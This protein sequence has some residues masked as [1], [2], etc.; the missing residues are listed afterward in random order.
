MPETKVLST[1]KDP[2]AVSLQRR[3]GN[4]RKRL[5]L[6]NKPFVMVS[7]FSMGIDLMIKT[8]P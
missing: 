8:P 3:K 1:G 4:S 5:T 7:N 2:L 6:S